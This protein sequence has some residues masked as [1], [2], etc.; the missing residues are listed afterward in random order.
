MARKTGL[1]GGSRRIFEGENGDFGG[2]DA[3]SGGQYSRTRNAG[4][5]LARTKVIFE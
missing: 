1:G 2:K 4:L 3:F 5:V